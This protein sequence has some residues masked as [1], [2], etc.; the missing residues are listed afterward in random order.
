MRKLTIQ[1]IIKIIPLDNNLKFRLLAEYDSYDDAA[2]SEII[3]TCY[4]AFFELEKAIK[5]TL[6][7]EYLEEVARG[8]REINDRFHDDMDRVVWQEIE[9][10]LN[11]KQE[12]QDELHEVRKQLEKI[13]GPAV[14]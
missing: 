3:H 10:R 1:E 11:G 5:D 13:I 2:K 8:D 4:G 9:A 6:Y 14:N 7:E 12:A